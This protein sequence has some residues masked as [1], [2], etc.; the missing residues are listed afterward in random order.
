MRTKERL[1]MN[2]S[3]ERADRRVV[4]ILL[5][6][7]LSTCWLVSVFSV[8]REMCMVSACSDAASFTLFGINLGWFGIANFTVVLVLLFLRKKPL[9]E[10]L[11]SGVVFAGIGA[12]FRLLWIQK[13]IIGAWCPLC[14]TICCSLF[15]AAI[16]LVIEKVRAGQSPHGKALAGWIAFVA[17]MS[18]IGLIIALIGVQALT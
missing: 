14:V 6:I 5:W 12:E 13:Y 8:I 10:W 1:G 9:V 15:L 18:S 4:S 2:H 3:S 11:L 17:A 16:L 7:A